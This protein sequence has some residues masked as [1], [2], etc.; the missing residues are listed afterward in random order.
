[1]PALLP[2]N[3]NNIKKQKPINYLIYQQ[4]QSLRGKLAQLLPVD[5]QNTRNRN[6]AFSLQQ[7]NPSST[8]AS[9]HSSSREHSN[10]DGPLVPIENDG[11]NL[12][13][14][15]LERQ[16][17][18]QLL[19]PPVRDELK[20]IISTDHIQPKTKRKELK[21]EE[22]VDELEEEQ[23]EE[24]E[25]LITVEKDEQDQITRSTE[26]TMHV[27]AEITIHLNRE[28]SA[29]DPPCTASMNQLNTIP[30]TIDLNNLS[31]EQATILLNQLDAGRFFL[32]PSFVSHNTFCNNI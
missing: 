22:E 2:S 10:R 18:Q 24:I 21:S 7:P 20:E 30:S 27:P 32:D 26:K 23:E 15:E 12:R 25:E 9:S 28:S 14:L 13:S 19:V 29:E 3:R 8:A 31:F 1:M 17:I 6:A 16:A 5:M 11:Y 4:H